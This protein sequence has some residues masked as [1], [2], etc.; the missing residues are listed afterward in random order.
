MADVPS[1]GSGLYGFAGYAYPN[2]RNQTI[3]QSIF[4][5]LGD[6]YNENAFYQPVA[7]TPEAQENYRRQLFLESFML[8]Y[9]F[10]TGRGNRA[11]LAGWSNSASL[12][13]TLEGAGW[14]AQ[15]TTLYIA[16]LDVEFTP[17][18]EEV[19][20]SADQFTWVVRERAGLNE[21]TPLD[22]ALQPGDEVIFRFTPLPDAVLGQVKE[23]VL[24]LEGSNTVSRTLPM[25]LW[26]WRAGAWREIEVPSNGPRAISNPARFLGPQ[27]MVE[28]RI[29]ADDLASYVRLQNLTVE[30][31]G[32]F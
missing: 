31:V 12:P 8:D 26:D 13:V 27:N 20:I 16:Q 24:E 9:Y 14:N 32:L 1:P 28:I 17:P 23:L 4:D 29:V 5:L 6:S 25:Q 11:Y 7:E 10:A 22:I 2:N 30:H 19:L 21:V 15:D 18:T 3:R